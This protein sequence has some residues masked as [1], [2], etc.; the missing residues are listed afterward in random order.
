MANP[1]K[2]EN[3]NFSKKIN[4]KKNHKKQLTK[5]DIKKIKR[6]KLNQYWEDMTSYTLE[7]V[8]LGGFVFSGGLSL[9][10]G[11]GLFIGGSIIGVGKEIYNY[12]L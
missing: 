12:I 9:L 1:R 7:K 6:I 3:T 2:Y 4:Y 5:E 11:S 10:L 8:A